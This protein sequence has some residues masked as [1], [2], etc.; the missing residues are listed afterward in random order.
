MNDETTAPANHPNF[1]LSEDVENIDIMTCRSIQ[2]F[3]GAHHTPG[4][5]ALVANLVFIQI[6]VRDALVDFK[7]LGQGL[8]AATDQGWRLVRWFYGQNLISEIPR[9]IDIQLRHVE[10]L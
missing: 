4:L 10:S 1:S 6:D 5:G 3:C 9:T 2:R 7:C 8:E